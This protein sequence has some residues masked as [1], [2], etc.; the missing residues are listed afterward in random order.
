M[1]LCFRANAGLNGLNRLISEQEREFFFFSDE[2]F[3]IDVFTHGLIRH[4][5]EGAKLTD[6]NRD[7]LTLNCLC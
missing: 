7:G 2:K 6:I 4:I 1:Q 5:S 3:I